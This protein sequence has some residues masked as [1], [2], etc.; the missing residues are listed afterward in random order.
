MAAQEEHKTVPVV[1]TLRSDG[2]DR[3]ISLQGWTVRTSKCPISNSKQIAALEDELGIPMPEMIFGGNSIS[4]EKDDGTMSIAFTTR[5]ALDAVDKTGTDLRVAYS[6][7]WNQTRDEHSEDIK[8]V[9]KPYD[10][11]YTSPY[12]GT[13]APASGWRDAEEGL[14]MELL[15]RQDPILFYDEVILYESELDDNGCSIYSC[16]V[17]VMPERLLLLARYFLRLDGV[18]FRIKDVRIYVEFATNKV[19]RECIDRQ[20]TF[21]SVKGRI[22]KYREDETGALMGD[23]NWVADK[24]PPVDGSLQQLHASE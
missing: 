6:E 18:T 14:P 24:C 9:T 8:Q 22:P 15:K 13:T 12:R 20:A 17:R 21:D 1:H 4:L 11:T 19:L 16:R 2:Y 7:H 3:S 10:W 23:Q 5:D